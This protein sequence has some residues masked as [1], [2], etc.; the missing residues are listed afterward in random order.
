MKQRIGPPDQ[1]LGNAVRRILGSPRLRKAGLSCAVSILY[2]FFFLQ[3]RAALIPRRAR[4]S[5][6]D[7]PL[8]KDIPFRPRWV[9]VYLDFTAFWIRCAGF[10]L[11]RYGR[12]VQGKVIEFIDSINLLYVRAAQVYTE[13]FSTTRRP[14]YYKSP[15]FLLIHALD[16]HLMC[17]PSLHVMLVIRSYTAFGAML[18]SLEGGEQFASSIE[19]C[20]RH[21]LDITEAI[22]YVKQHSVNCIPAALY[23]MTRFDP[24]LFP[25]EEAEA[26]AAAL[27]TRPGSPPAREAIR[28][29]IISLYRRFLAEGETADDWTA[30]LRAFLLTCP[31]QVN[32]RTIGCNRKL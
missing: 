25:P 2:H 16:P 27:F 4:I 19:D 23:A 7:H 13:N 15:R 32:R 29:H 18:R 10:P 30:P 31:R 8:D 3:Y 1:S 22:L 28:N 17:V 24:S 21:A 14:R 12:R 20:R 6:V 5:S 11:S 26:F 9:G